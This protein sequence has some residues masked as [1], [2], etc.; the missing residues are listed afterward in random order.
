MDQKEAIGG[1]GNTGVGERR[2]VGGPCYHRSQEAS[3]EEGGPCYQG[4]RR[5]EE[6]V[7]ELGPI[8]ACEAWWA[9]S[10][11]TTGMTTMV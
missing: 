3:L 7:L 10:W 4:L 11:A 9:G 5:L 1:A 6:G 2:L 8:Q